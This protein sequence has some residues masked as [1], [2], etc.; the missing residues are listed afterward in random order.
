MS[1]VMVEEGG[2]WEWQAAWWVGGRAGGG[3]AMCVRRAYVA[4]TA[5]RKVLSAPAN[6]RAFSCTCGSATVRERRP[7]M[8]NLRDTETEILSLKTLTATTIFASWTFCGV[9]FP[10]TASQKEDTR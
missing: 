6:K 10:V 3:Q 7:A 8:Q 1:G 5:S 2:L 9:E 4:V